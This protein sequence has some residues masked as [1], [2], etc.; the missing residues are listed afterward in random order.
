MPVTDYLP[1]VTGGP[2]YL[3][4]LFVF[5]PS[6]FFASGEAA[7]F[8]GESPVFAGDAD[9]DAVGLAVATGVGVAG[10]LFGTS[11]CCGFGSH[12]PRTATVAA[13]IVDNIIDLLIV[14]SPYCP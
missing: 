8:G 3:G 4:F 11:V 12:A 2:R 10:G 1:G 6:S 13:K 5:L 9:G 14:F 7:G